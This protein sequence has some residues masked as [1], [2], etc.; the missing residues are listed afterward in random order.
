MCIRDRNDLTWSDRE[1]TITD[2]ILGPHT[3][4]VTGSVS[5]LIV[6]KTDPVSLL[7]ICG[8][9]ILAK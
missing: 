8:R 3:S 6:C 2:S 4:D 9:V 1:A 7:T 5:P